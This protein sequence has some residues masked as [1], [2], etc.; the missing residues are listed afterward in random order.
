MA[1]IG[2]SESFNP[3]RIQKRTGDS[4]SPLRTVR[5]YRVTKSHRIKLY[6]VVIK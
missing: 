3:V 5:K 1:R 4:P 2:S 6:D